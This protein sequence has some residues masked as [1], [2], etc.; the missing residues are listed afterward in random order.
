M[1]FYALIRGNKGAPPR[2]QC[3]IPKININLQATILSRPCID[4]LHY[5]SIL[6]PFAYIAS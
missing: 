4:Q 3:I 1:S 2:I 6:K 5:K